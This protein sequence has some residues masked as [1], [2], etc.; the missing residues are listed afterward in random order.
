[1]STQNRTASIKRRIYTYNHG[2]CSITPKSTMATPQGVLI[3]F[4]KITWIRTRYVRDKQ[5][6]GSEDIESLLRDGDQ[7]SWPTFL[8]L[9]GLSVHSTSCC[10]ISSRVQ[11]MFRRENFSTNAHGEDTSSQ[12][13][14][15]RMLIISH[16]SLMVKVLP[17]DG[18]HRTA[19]KLFILS[20]VAPVFPQLSQMIELKAHHTFKWFQ[21]ISPL[22]T[23]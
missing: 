13:R 5:M 2:H 6:G 12:T 9:V 17:L 22:I 19:H 15:Y 20:W 3:K 11:T 21:E 1:M 18:T 16:F 4:Y 14:L 23:Q 8:S 7:N 10:Y